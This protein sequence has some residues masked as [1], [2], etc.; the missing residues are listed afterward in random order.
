MH[1]SGGNAR[2]AT[3]QTTVSVVVPSY[4]A[5]CVA[6]CLHALLGQTRP[7]DEIVV[8]HFVEDDAVGDAARAVGDASIAI[9]HAATRGF[10]PSIVAGVV[11]TSGDI[12]VLTDDD[13]VA[14][15]D[16]LARMLGY[17]ED[18]KVGGVGGRD[19]VHTPSGELHPPAGVELAVGLIT[20]WGKLIGN[21]HVGTGAPRSVMVLKGV[22]MGFRRAAFAIPD[23]VRGRRIQTHTEVAIC[24]WARQRGWDLV[25]D[26]TLIV[27]HYPASR[28]G[29]SQRDRLSW[30]A[31]HDRSYNLVMGVAQHPQASMWRRAVYGLAIGDAESPGL[32]RGAVAFARGESLVAR[33]MFPALIGQTAALADLAR[34]R[35][36]VMRALIDGPAGEPRPA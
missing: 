33:R 31:E 32:A 4:R 2:T 3:P 11:R 17:F 27:H 20:R 21:H 28:R 16:W 8:A 36:I 10:M 35:R 18:P 22:N 26:P 34:G 15:A 29:E 1:H 24:G 14:P 7:P 6:D 12:V 25:Y 30:D 23:G 5:D 13:A 19:I 9:A